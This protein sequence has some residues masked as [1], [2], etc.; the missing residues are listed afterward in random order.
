MRVEI[1]AGPRRGSAGL[2]VKVGV[3]FF[4]GVVFVVVKVDF[5]Q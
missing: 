3:K 1:L 5:A 2:A 4:S